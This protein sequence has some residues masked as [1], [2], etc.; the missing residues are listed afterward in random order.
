M[1]PYSVPGVVAFGTGDL[2]G[3]AELGRGDCFAGV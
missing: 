3:L 2:A 1:N